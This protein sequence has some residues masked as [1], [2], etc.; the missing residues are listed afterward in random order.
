MPWQSVS[1]MSSWYVKEKNV[2]S[3]SAFQNILVLSLSL[4][5]SVPPPHKMADW[6]MCDLEFCSVPCTDTSFERKW[7]ITPVTDSFHSSSRIIWQFILEGK[8]EFLVFSCQ[9]NKNR[10]NC[11]GNIMHCTVVVLNSVQAFERRE[12]FL[13]GIWHVKNRLTGSCFYWAV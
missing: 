8:G 12:E 7:W 3:F 2:I 6:Q 10:K 9:T 4:S 13:F 1:S 5:L 11:V